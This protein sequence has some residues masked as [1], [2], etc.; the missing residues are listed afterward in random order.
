M[1][2]TATS[3]LDYARLVKDIERKTARQIGQRADRLGVQMEKIIAQMIDSELGPTSGRAAKRGMVP[4]RDILW[5]HT[6]DNPGLLPI[7]VTMYSNDLTGPTG[8]KFG[9]LNYGWSH[10]RSGASRPLRQGETFKGGYGGNDWLAR[11]GRIAAARAA[12]RFI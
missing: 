6:V 8:A 9:A 4:M 1:E 11:T 2:L 10:Q 3:T 5:E 7:H 12:A